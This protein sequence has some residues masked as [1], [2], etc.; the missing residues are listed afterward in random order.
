MGK[1]LFD[2]KILALIILIILLVLGMFILPKLY[3]SFDV[4]DF[5]SCINAGNPAME[6]YPRQCR[7]GGD[8]FV[9]V[10]DGC[11]Q[12]ENEEC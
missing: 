2:M 1:K 8:T 12:F 7:D 3:K 9:E 4:N 10:V 5:E 6:S 11:G